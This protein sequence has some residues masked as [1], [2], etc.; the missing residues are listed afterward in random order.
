MFDGTNGTPKATNGLEQ[1]G[2]SLSTGKF[3]QNVP[4]VNGAGNDTSPGAIAVI[5]PNNMKVE[6]LFTISL[7]DCA[8]PQGMA[9]GPNDQI[10]EGCNA[11]GPNGSRNTVVVSAK[12]GKILAVFQ[13]LGGND[14]VWFNPGDNH[15]IIPSC[16]TA[17]RTP[18][19]MFNLTGDEVLELVDAATLQRD[20]LVLS[21]RRTALRWL[22][23]V[24][25]AP[26]LGRGR[27]EQQA[28]HP[29]NP[30]NWR[31]S[32]T[33]CPVALRQDGI[34]NNSNRYAIQCDRLHR[35]LGSAVK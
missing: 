26:Y 2:W 9:I 21:P 12:N 25:R 13:D 6:K 1:C 3:Y 7:E 18:P 31:Y 30:G 22:P 35:R 16:N 24:I 33:V 34:G 19:G 14:E 27:S 5:N 23:L 29:A 17:C 15:Y 11:K 8:G 10:L 32:T 4:E 28:D 20:Q